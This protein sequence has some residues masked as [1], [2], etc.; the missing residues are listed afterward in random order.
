MS[1]A[2]RSSFPSA[3]FMRT[4]STNDIPR[5]SIGGLRGGDGVRDRA[6]TVD[7]DRDLVAGLQPDRRFAKGADARR[8]AGGDQVARPERDRL[9]GE[10]DP[11]GH[12]EEP[13][14]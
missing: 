6:D 4:T 2:A 7:L 3:T 1:C 10:P 12:P 9:R 13:I 14:R 5:P 11:P 8:R